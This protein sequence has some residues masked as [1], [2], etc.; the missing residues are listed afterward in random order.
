MDTN[1]PVASTT[2]TPA[3]ASPGMFGTS[4]T[5]S[6]AFI[7]AILMFLLP[8]SEIKCGDSTLMNKSGLG[9]AMGQEWKFAG[10][11]GQ[12]MMKDMDTKT[13]K[14]KEG[15]AQMFIIAALGLG[16]LGLLASFVKSK[17]AGGIGII[18]G[19]LGAGTLIAFMFDVKKWFNDGLAKEA[20][21]KATDGADSIGLDKI[22]DTMNN[23]KPTLAFTP[24]FY[25]AIV[26]FVAAAFF[27]YKRMSSIKS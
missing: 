22:G 17:G 10:G 24:W 19:I 18:A 3:P 26:A 20:A 15:N 16:V 9:F 5:S 6:V 25:V 12:D 2:Y 11:M 4:I 8:F 23:M 21:E 1:Q 14:K 7:V 27:C 13:G